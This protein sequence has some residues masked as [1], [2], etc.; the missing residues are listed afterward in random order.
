MKTSKNILIAFILNLMLSVFELFGGIFT[1]SVAIISDAVHDVGDAASIGLSYFLEKKSRKQPDESYTYGYI[2]YSVL[3][4][5]LTTLILVIGSVAVITNAVER[6]IN[7]SPINYTGMIVFAII[8]VVVN[9]LA[10]YYTH[11]DGSLNQKA[12]NLHMIEDVLGWIVVLVGAIVMRFTDFYLID[13]LMSIGVAVFILFN[14]VRNLKKVLDLFLMKTPDKFE[15]A[16]IKKKIEEID[17]VDE[18]HHIHITSID[19]ENAYVTLHVVT[20]EFA[21]DIKEKIRHCLYHMGVSHT[22]IEIES[23]NENCEHKVCI[24]KHHSHA[25]CHHHH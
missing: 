22:T 21:S 10:A 11:G 19:G 12:V 9:F 16:D 23:S 15:V 13:P 6:I 1:G 24:V 4:S 3:G 8:G 2:R 7:P 5:L 18:A 25:H 14:A 17:G 20:D